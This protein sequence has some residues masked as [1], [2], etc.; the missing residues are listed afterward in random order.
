MIWDLFFFSFLFCDKLFF[1]WD[2]W[3]MVLFIWN[4]LGHALLGEGY[5]ILLESWFQGPSKCKHQESHPS[6][7]YVVY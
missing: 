5:P 1:V 2:L 7:S 3:Y 4:F 6:L